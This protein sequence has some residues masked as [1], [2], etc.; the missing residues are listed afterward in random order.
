[1]M[2]RSARARLTLVLVVAACAAACGQSTGSPTPRP[3]SSPAASP[4][5]GG[6]PTSSPPSGPTGSFD[7]GAVA[8]EL[9]PVADIPGNPLAVV[10]AGDG[11][12]R[13]FVVDRGGRIW[14]VREGQVLDT[15]F[16]DIADQVRAGGEQGLLGL[17]FHPGFPDDPRF[18]VYYTAA[19]DA[20]Q[21][22]S[23][24]RVAA[25]DADRADQR[26]E[27]VLLRM[28]DF[29]GNHNGGALAFGPDG[30]LYISTGDGGG[31]GDPQRNGQNNGQLLGKVLRVDVSGPAEGRPYGIPADNPFVDVSGAAPEIWV[32]GLRNPWRMSFDR[33]TGDLWIGDVGQGSFEEV[34]VVRAGSGG[35]QNFGWNLTEGFHCYPSREA[36]APDGLVPPVTEYDHGSGC[37]ITGGYVYRGTAYPEL[38]GGYVFGDYCSGNLWLIDPGTDEAREPHLAGETGRSI[39]AFGEDEKGELYV[40]DLNAGELLRLVARPR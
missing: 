17:A 40:T 12:N 18:F 3:T 25:S 23:E 28:D 16:L 26:S 32:T 5:R 31:G 34:D 4:A 27:S 15:P 11:T 35:G 29:A 20:R 1:M 13:L 24:W 19:S 14:I 10:N 8:L 6:G 33:E 30:F 2:T 39:S 7:P 38:A 21:V 22:V 9:E 37:S 36:C